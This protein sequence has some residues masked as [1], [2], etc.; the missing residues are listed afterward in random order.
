MR[1]TLKIEELMMFI[2]S[3]V[4]FNQLSFEWWWYLALF[5]LPDLSFLGYLINTK[6]GAICYNILHHKGIAIIFW[7]LGF[8]LQN[9]ILQLIGIVLFGHASF[10]RVLGYG[11]KYF[12]SFNNTHLGKV[13]KN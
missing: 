5:F 12:D 11:L 8:Y 1:N 6:V 7:L 4:F 13:G 2:L 10:D 9:E 3:M